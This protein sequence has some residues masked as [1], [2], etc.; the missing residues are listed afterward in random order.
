MHKH[1]HMP[2]CFLQWAQCPSRSRSLYVSSQ[3]PS[4][5]QWD[6]TTLRICTEDAWI[7]EPNEIWWRNQQ[8]A[9][10]MKKA[11]GWC[12]DEYILQQND[13]QS[14]GVWLAH[15]KHHYGQ[16]VEPSCY[17]SQRGS[18]VRDMLF[19]L[20]ENIF[21]NAPSSNSRISYCG[22]ALHN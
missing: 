8:A 13:N 20:L 15:E 22:V 21:I 11:R 16:H 6:R 12:I 2:I 1:L 14:Q 7:I 4:S 9:Q 3:P 18:L 19:I 5:S 17:H 10:Q